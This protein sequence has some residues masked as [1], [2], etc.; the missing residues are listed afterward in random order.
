[1]SKTSSRS[2]RAYLVRCWQAQSID[3]ERPAWHFSVEEI[4]PQ[5]HRRGFDSLA[6]FLAF[7]SAEFAA[8]SGESLDNARRDSP[9]PST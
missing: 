2:D 9:R 6:A 8:H 4:S 7:W 1:V 3:D 5:P